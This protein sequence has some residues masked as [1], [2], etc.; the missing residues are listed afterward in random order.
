MLISVLIR[1]TASQHA[2]AVASWWAVGSGS[3]E[4]AVVE[5]DPAGPMSAGEALRDA[6]GR[7]LAVSAGPVAAG[8][9]PAYD[10]PPLPFG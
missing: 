5:W 6:L 8:R 10:Q 2:R 7:L 9:A 4:L 3:H 1:R